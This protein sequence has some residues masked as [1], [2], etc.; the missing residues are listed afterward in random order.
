MLQKQ[1]ATMG[2]NDSKAIEK[3]EKDEAAKAKKAE[4][5]LQKRK[6]EIRKYDKLPSDKIIIGNTRHFY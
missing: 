2:C 5:D 6:S 4:E 3:F 1:E